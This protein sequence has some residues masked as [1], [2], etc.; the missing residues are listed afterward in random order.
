MT[1][2]QAAGVVNNIV[3]SLK[4][5]PLII[6]LLAVVVIFQGANFYM[7]KSRADFEKHRLDERVILFKK[8]MDQ[9]GPKQ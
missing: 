2:E 3:N 5:Q 6:G 4:G 1:H 8:L 7:E 9:C